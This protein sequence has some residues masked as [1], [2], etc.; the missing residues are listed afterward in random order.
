MSLTIIS[1]AAALRTIDTLSR[2][3]NRLN[4]SFERLASGLRINMAK[5][6]VAGFSIST[7]MESK[8]R[9]QNRGIQNTGDAI[10]MTQIADGGLKEGAHIVQ[11]M[12]ELAVQAANDTYGESDRQS[13]NDE[14]NQLNTELG[15]LTLHTTYNGQKLLHE[16]MI[17]KKIQIGDEVNIGGTV[18]WLSVN[19]AGTAVSLPET[20]YG[21]WWSGNEPEGLLTQEQAEKTLG[22]IGQAIDNI[23]AQRTL[24]GA[25]EARLFAMQNNL[26]QAVVENSSARSKI[27]DADLAQETASLAVNTIT[28]DASAAIL[29][30][31]NQQPRLAMQLFS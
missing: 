21:S 29:V 24:I 30:Q 15:R 31:A 11:R 9:E 17:G 3:S 12:W 26:A 1:N 22:V 7:R 25:F 13:M 2:S 16:E 6:D 27:R 20:G 10:S 23:G 4:Q 8:I 14:F 18:E 19:D 5:D 28:Q